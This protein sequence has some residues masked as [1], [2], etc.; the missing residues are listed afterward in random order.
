M[1]DLELKLLESEAT[2]ERLNII[3]KK[4]ENIT[5]PAIQ[6][7]GGE[8]ILKEIVEK[9]N[10]LEV[11]LETLESKDKASAHDERNLIKK[12]NILERLNELEKVNL[13]KMKKLS[14]LQQILR[15]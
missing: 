13:E 11:R 9:L 3:E 15:N 2:V 6:N 10:N 12:R 1:K 5:A 7:I 14:P 8:V 4:I